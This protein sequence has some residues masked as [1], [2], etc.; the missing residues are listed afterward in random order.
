MPHIH[1][2][3]SDYFRVDSTGSIIDHYRLMSSNDELKLLD[4]AP[5]G[6]GAMYHRWCFDEISGYNDKLKYQEDYD[7]WL[8]FINRFNVYNVR[9]PLMYYRQHDSSM[10]TNKEKRMM[11]RRHVK[12]KF[13][14]EKGGIQDLNIVG[15]VPASVFLKKGSSYK[16]P[17]VD[18]N[19]NPLI[20]YPITALMECEYIKE[21]YIATDGPEVEEMARKLGAQS[22]GLQPKDIS[23]SNV[24]IEEVVRYHLKEMDTAGIEIPDLIFTISPNHPFIKSHHVSEA[25]DTMLIND[26]D[27]VISVIEHYD[28]KWTPGPYGLVPLGFDRKMVKKD[29]ETIYIETGGIRVVKTKNLLG[30]NWLGNSVGFIELT[31]TDSLSVENN[32]LS[33]NMV[34]KMFKEGYGDVVQKDEYLYGDDRDLK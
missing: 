22:M 16:F 29:H 7:F 31:S 33:I 25:I 19:G 8:K 13:I 1:M 14:K 11:A 3:Y 27:S 34:S 4:R 26:Y 21:V 10:S 17:L 28:F 15:L 5:L 23:R 32:E 12:K 6:A 18:I 9:L 24:S 2:V 30:E 20:H